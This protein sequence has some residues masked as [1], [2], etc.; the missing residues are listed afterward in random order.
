MNRS[1]VRQALEVAHFDG[2]SA[3]VTGAASG[4]GKALA[5]ELVY[6]GATVL[7]ADIDGSGAA[8]V[9][10]SLDRSG[11]GS[12]SAVTLDVTDAHAVT[13]AVD[14]FAGDH[15][16]LDFLFNNA[17]VGVGGEVREMTS[18]HWQR[19]IDVNLLGVVH[20]V[21]AAYPRMI[22]QGRGHIVNTASL[23]G[24]VPSPLLVPYS[25]TK[26]AV[27]GLSVG[28][29]VEAADHGVRISVVCPGVIDTPLLDKPNPADLPH[30][31]S[32]PDVRDLLTR[33]VGMPYP[34]ASLAR[35]V[36]DR[37]ALNRAII[38][39]PRHARLA[40]AAYRLAPGLLIDQSPR[41]V[42]AVAGPR[43]PRRR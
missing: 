17:G 2:A 38:V 33:M 30:A 43:R 11:P 15:G 42:R 32:M 25:T 10:G 19:V 18:A 3:V 41:R 34:A 40:W 8:A 5:T 29:R 26:H 21:S 20:G 35:D 24:L 28:L 27:V 14:R 23:A 1:E 7:V 16:G 39:S 12:A 31:G 37:V 6:R 13:R 22:E 4:I 9:G 36:L